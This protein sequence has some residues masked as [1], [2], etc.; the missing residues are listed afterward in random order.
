MLE[1]H[2]VDVV[3]NVADARNEVGGQ[4]RVENP[5][6]VYLEVLGDGIAVRLHDTAVH[7]PEDKLG[8]DRSAGIGGV[9]HAVDPD[10]AGLDVDRQVDGL[11][12]VA[13][14]DV[15][16]AGNASRGR[17]VRSAGG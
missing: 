4:P 1:H 10:V 11:G 5:P 17:A 2:A 8:V 7:L 9:G 6:V 14:R 15:A 16:V 12:D 13:E 3:G